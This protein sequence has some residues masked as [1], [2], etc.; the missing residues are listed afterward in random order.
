MTDQHGGIDEAGEEL[1]AEGERDALEVEVALQDFFQVAGA[2]ARQQRGG[3]DDGESA[4]RDECLGDGFAVL[5]A[6]GDVLQ[7]G[8]EVGQLLAAGQ[9]LD[10]A[11]DGKAGADEGEELL[12]EDE[13]GLQLDLLGLAGA[14][15]QAARLHRVDVVP[16]LREARAQL[17]FGGRGVRLLLHAA[18]LIRQSDYKLSHRITHHQ[19][20]AKS[21]AALDRKG[22][23][24]LRRFC[25]ADSSQNHCGSDFFG[26]D[27]DIAA[28][29]WSAA[30]RGG[31]A[32]GAVCGSR[33]F[34][35]FS[36][37]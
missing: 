33:R 23:F 4:L 1:L 36:S 24:H 27:F 21:I 5:D 30:C 2:L 35:P 26:P 7:L 32:C 16:R 8:A 22:P 17:F 6:G 14:R 11:E 31:A 13:K 34:R 20:P 37:C 12:V 10:G 25:A 28:A 18:T 29:A 9:Q 15:Q 3:V 19:P